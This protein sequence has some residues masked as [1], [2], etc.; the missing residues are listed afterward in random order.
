MRPS[1]MNS[2][3]VWRTIILDLSL[4]TAENEVEIDLQ[5]TECKSDTSY[6]YCAAHI[7]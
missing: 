4:D 3:L 5:T 2:V 1:T 6:L 7:G